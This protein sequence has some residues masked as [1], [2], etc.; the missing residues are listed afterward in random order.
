MTANKVHNRLIRLSQLGTYELFLG[1]LFRSTAD[2]PI[3]IKWKKEDGRERYYRVFWDTSAYTGI[4]SSITKQEKGQY[5]LQTLNVD[6][7]WRTIDF[8]TITNWSWMGI[9]Y[10]MK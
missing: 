10:T 7:E 8:T 2:M 5:N 9:Y 4:Q 6:G 1:H 3:R